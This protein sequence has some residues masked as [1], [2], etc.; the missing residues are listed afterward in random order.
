M[1]AG[2]AKKKFTDVGPSLRILNILL[3]LLQLNVGLSTIFGLI[4]KP[5]WSWSVFILIFGLGIYINSFFFYS[6]ET[7]KKNDFQHSL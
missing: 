6:V 3:G 7:T 1:R 2:L 4:K 5:G